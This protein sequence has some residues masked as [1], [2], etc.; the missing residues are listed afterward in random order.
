MKN[1]LQ[2]SLVS[3]FTLTY[4]LSAQAQ[5][6]L[7]DAS[8]LSIV[9]YD[10]SDQIFCFVGCAVGFSTPA[11]E[12][13]AYC[14][15]WDFGNGGTMTGNSGDEIFSCF[16]E[17]GTHIVNL[18]LTCCDDPGDFMVYTQAIDIVC[19]ETPSCAVPPSVSFTT[20]IDTFFSPNIICWGCSAEVCGT[21]LFSDLPADFPFSPELLCMDIEFSNGES[22]QGVPLG[23]CRTSCYGMDSEGSVCITVYC[24]EDPDINF[25][26]CS[27]FTL[28][29]P[30]DVPGCTYV[31]ADNYNPNATVDDGSCILTCT[32]DCDGD[33]NGDGTVSVADILILLTQFGAICE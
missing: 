21:V 26:S 17:P 16:N 25:T 13:G 14:I 27:D 33:V 29:E 2:I 28:C 32:N 5:C 11:L 31:T 12:D 7:P 8:D 9:S 18:M 20:T 1:L 6:S 19:W 15:T 3:L 23:E 24:C 30:V 4:T 10:M 22:F